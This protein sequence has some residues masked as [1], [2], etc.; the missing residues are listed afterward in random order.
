MVSYLSTNTFLLKN[1]FRDIR[2]LKDGVQMFTKKKT[3]IMTDDCFHK[4]SD[5]KLQLQRER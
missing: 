1:V 3:K 5:E 2:S 4:V